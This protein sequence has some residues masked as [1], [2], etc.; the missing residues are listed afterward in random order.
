M[1]RRG[2][3][4]L[5]AATLGAVSV[6]GCTGRDGEGNGDGDD[7]SGDGGD[8]ETPTATEP[9][10]G[11][12]TPTATDP[13]GPTETA[14]REPPSDPDQRVLVGDGLSFDPESFEVA[15]GETVLW[16]W[17]GS[18]HNIKYDEGDVPSESS[19][20]GTAGPRTKTY[21]E[22][23]RHWHTFEV[24]GEYAYYCVPHRSNGM[25]GSFTVSE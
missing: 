17:V 13:D 18:G 21:G 1:D 23:H 7:G 19:W 12:E 2:Y 16:E 22:G 3:V 14:T 25:T 10:D 24:A 6:A 8:T 20:E 9:G 11:E 4:R 15:V 5:V